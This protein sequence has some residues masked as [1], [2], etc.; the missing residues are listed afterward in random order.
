LRHGCSSLS[1][2]NSRKA[3]VRSE[4]NRSQR[5]DSAGAYYE[6]HVAHIEL[7]V[8]QDLSPL[9]A[10][11]LEIELLLMNLIHNAAQADGGSRQIMIGTEQAADAER[12]PVQD[13]VPGTSE[14]AQRH[15]FESFY[16]TR[17]YESSPDLSI[18]PVS[19]PTTTAR[20]TPTGKPAEEPLWRLSY[21]SRPGKN[22]YVETLLAPVLGS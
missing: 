21:P 17:H 20:F 14:E 3:T 4:R 7:A 6:I 18:A 12:L 8:Q 1:A 19:S 9:S 13:N 22:E 5:A 11:A 16:S 15:A 10:N 2:G